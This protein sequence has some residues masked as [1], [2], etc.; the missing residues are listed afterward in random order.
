MEISRRSKALLGRFKLPVVL[1]RDLTID[2]VILEGLWR[3][4]KFENGAIRFVLT[5]RLGEAFLSEPGQVS[6][7]RPAGGGGKLAYRPSMAD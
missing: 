5:P 1:P 4:K 7:G 2:A 3:D 6:L